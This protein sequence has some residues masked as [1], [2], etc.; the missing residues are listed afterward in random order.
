MSQ[1]NLQDASESQLST[2][3][4]QKVGVYDNIK[5]TEVVLAETSVNKVPYIELKTIG[6]NGEVGRSNKM[7]LST[8]TKPGKT[9][10][11]WAITARNIVDLLVNTHNINRD[12]AKALIAV[13][14]TQ[15][16]VT[17]LSALLIGKPFRAKFKGEEGQ[18]PGVIYPTMDIT[19]SMKVPIAETRLSFN[20]DR[21]I[22]KYQGPVA[23][24]IETV[25]SI[26]GNDNL[27][28]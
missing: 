16:L 10:S 13:D 4:Y 21:D 6:Q 3:N 17:K 27:P 9:T 8:D 11:A 26:N 28:F 14:N 2:V 7:F 24:T 20:P 15:Q 19:E 18:K 1:F 23:A 12:E 25:D 5:I 22:K